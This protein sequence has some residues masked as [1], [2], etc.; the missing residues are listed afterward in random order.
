MAI[1]KHYAFASYRSGIDNCCKLPD[2]SEDPESH[3]DQE[4]VARTTFGDV[5]CMLIARTLPTLCK[6]GSFL[7]MSFALAA[8]DV[9]MRTSGLPCSASSTCCSWVPTASQWLRASSKGLSFQ[10]DSMHDSAGHAYLDQC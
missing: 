8:D 9:R 10:S 7:A 3:K 4:K 1:S 5:Y 2:F 6:L